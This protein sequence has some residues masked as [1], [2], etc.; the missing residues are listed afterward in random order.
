[1]FW[2][3]EAE[4]SSLRA[5]EAEKLDFEAAKAGYDSLLDA[6]SKE[7]EALEANMD[8]THA[9]KAELLLAMQGRLAEVEEAHHADRVLLAS[10]E[11]EL[12]RLR[13]EL[14]GLRDHTQRQAPP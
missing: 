9:N 1:M 6:K 10:R 11:V 8:S 3:W 7:I 12:M 5:L 4:L 2:A 13:E 14:R